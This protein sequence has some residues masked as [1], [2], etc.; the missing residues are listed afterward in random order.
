[1]KLILTARVFG[2]ADRWEATHANILPRTLSAGLPYV[3]PTSTSGSGRASLRTLSN[4]RGSVTAEIR[5]SHHRR[6]ITTL[7]A[8]RSDVHGAY[9]HYFGIV[10]RIAGGRHAQN[11]GSH[12]S[13]PRVRVIQA[14]TL[15]G[16]K[17]RKERSRL[18]GLR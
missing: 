18:G 8:R 12:E 16:T 1:M 2:S 15:G 13:A 10:Q 4:R 9:M 6:T 14:R 7:P 11:D 3:V 5:P 17:E